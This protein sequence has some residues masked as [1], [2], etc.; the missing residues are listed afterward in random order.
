MD[1]V[2]KQILHSSLVINLPPI[3]IIDAKD[4]TSKKEGNITPAG[5]QEAEKKGKKQKGRDNNNAAQK[6]IKNYHMITKFKMKEGEDWLRDLASKNTK[7]RSKWNEKCWMCVRWFT[8][9]DCFTDCNNKEI[10]VDAPNIPTKKKTQ[11]LNFLNRVCGNPM[12]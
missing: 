11:Y 3:F 6:H 10:R 7:D 1:P 5:Q 12:L 8:K 9:G 4:P 2:I